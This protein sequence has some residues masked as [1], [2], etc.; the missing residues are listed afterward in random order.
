MGEM[1]LFSA[2]LSYCCGECHVNA[3]TDS[4]DWASDA[5]PT[6]VIARRM[7]AMVVAINKQNFGGGN[8]VTCWT[9]HR[10]SP[11]PAKTAS[12]DIIYGEP[13]IFPEDV[14]KAAPPGFQLLHSC[15]AA[16]VSIERALST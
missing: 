7:A 13:L 1:G 16:L 6:K 15:V 5:K 2:A 12:P 3:G 14:L 9:C 11:T 8:N 10:G 4:P